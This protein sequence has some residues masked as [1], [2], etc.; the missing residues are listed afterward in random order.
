VFYEELFKQLNKKHIDYVIVGGVAL[1]MHGIVRFTADLDLMLHLE[2]KNLRRFI[3]IMNELG[4][5]PRVPVRAEGLLDAGQ[6]KQ[7]AEEKNMLVFSFHHPREAISLVDI[8]IREPM[9]FEEIK[10][11]AVTMKLGNLAVPVISVDDMIKMKG[12]SDRP[13]D[14]EDIKALKRLQTDEKND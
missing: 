7:W 6:R 14:A 4:Y 10:A 5:K 13:Q 2:E 1:V 12:R 11:H 9:P 8:F 3:N